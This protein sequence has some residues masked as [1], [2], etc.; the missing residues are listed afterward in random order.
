MKIHSIQLKNFLCYYG[1]NNRID[2][3]DGLNLV[4]GANGYGKSKLYDAFQWV[5]KDGITD[6][7]VTGRLKQTEQLKKALI[8]DKA[9]AEAKIGDKLKCEVIIEVT[10]AQ[11]TY[12]L[13]RKYF[14][15]KQSDEIWIE[16][17]SSSLDVYKKDVIHFKPVSEVFAQSITQK[18]IPDEVMPYVWFQGERGVNSIIDTSSKDSLKRVIERL[19][20]IE[21]WDEY[22]AIAEKASNTASNQFNFALKSATKNRQDYDDLIKKQ[23]DAQSK[24]AICIEELKN[25]QK[26]REAASEKSNAVI[27][28]LS[29]ANKIS[30]I[31]RKKDD[32]IKEYKNVTSEIENAHLN[33]TKGLF[34][35]SWLLMDTKQF[36]SKYE[37]KYNRYIESLRIRKTTEDLASQSQDRLPRGIPE[38]MHVQS[39]LDKQHCLVC[40]RPAKIGTPEYKAIEQLL[41]DTAAK[42]NSIKDIEYDLRKLWNV[43]FTLSDKSNKADQEIIE[44][45]KKKD[46]LVVRQKE[47]KDEIEALVSSVNNE[48]LNSGIE[49]AADIIAMAAVSN[50][51]LQKYSQT[52]GKLERDKDAL[53]NSLKFFESKLKSLSIGEIDPLITKKMELLSD[54]AQLAIRIKD[55]EYKGLVDLLQMKANEHYERINKP[56]GAF[57]GNIKFIETTGGGFIPEIFD[58]SG[59]RVSNLNTSQTS[60]MKLAIIMAIITA[61]HNRGYADRYPLIA[62]AP[63]SDFDAKKAKSF[64]IEASNTFSQSIIIVMDYLI[65]DTTRTNRYSPDSKRLKDLRDSLQQ[66]GKSINVIQ[67]DLPTG[68]VSTNRKELSI[69]IKPVDVI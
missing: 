66:E 5:F 29:S 43:G 50:Q 60:S 31:E 65:D 34:K 12:Q 4:L 69:N 7:K 64:L 49:K 6:E 17:R 10:L 45:I 22:I 47:L 57:Y 62:D 59:E 63:I 30:L 38:R 18:L 40:D 53:E 16:G 56:T 35:E 46:E 3:K 1:E 19:S 20:D 51:D 8:S 41:P 15:T 9:L 2:F 26:N 68:V 13:I 58:D 25:A 24:L 11:E 37:E 67:L 44:A 42:K 54:L 48:I 39:M 32:K 28:K 61:N 14:A 27:G 33:F 21:R 55:T 52:I 36:I 23:N